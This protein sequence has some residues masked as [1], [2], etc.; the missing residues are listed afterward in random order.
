MQKHRKKKTHDHTTQLACFNCGRSGSFFVARN[1]D[2]CGNEE[3]LVLLPTCSRC[4]KYDDEVVHDSMD[5]GRGTNATWEAACLGHEERDSGMRQDQEDWTALLGNVRPV[6]VEATRGLMPNLQENLNQVFGEEAVDAIVDQ[7]MYGTWQ[8]D[9]RQDSLSLGVATCANI[10]NL[11]AIGMWSISQQGTIQQIDLISGEIRPGTMIRVH[12]FN[13]DTILVE[14]ACSS[15]DVQG[16]H[17]GFHR[18]IFSQ[19]FGLFIRSTNGVHSFT[20]DCWNGEGE[21]TLTY[22]NPQRADQWIIA[23]NHAQ[24][25]HPDHF[26]SHPI[27]EVSGMLPECR[28]LTPSVSRYLDYQQELVW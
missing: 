24:H 9:S 20:L 13:E 15:H 4:M 11:S 1:Q 3:K 26:V 2:E 10:A 28:M 6:L 8:R 5:Q 19:S 17:A 18:G 21:R 22:Q 25:Q 7:R 14:P 23:C 27:L 12:W 16:I